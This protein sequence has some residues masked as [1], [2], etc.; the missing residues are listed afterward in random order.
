MIDIDKLKNH[1]N[2]FK[3]SGLANSGSIKI[4]QMLLKDFVKREFQLLSRN[5]G[6]T[7]LYQKILPNS[8]ILNLQ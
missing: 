5:I 6:N 7:L 4:E 8:K 2:D 1:F 3:K